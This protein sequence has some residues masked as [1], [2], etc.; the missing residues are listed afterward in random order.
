MPWARVRDREPR[1]LLQTPEREISGV[2][3]S[4]FRDGAYVGEL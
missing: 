1:L 4:I 2:T 3:T